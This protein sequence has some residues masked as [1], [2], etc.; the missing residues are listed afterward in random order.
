MARIANSLATRLIVF[1]LLLVIAGAAARFFLLPKFLSAGLIRVVSAQQTVLA[2]RVARDIDYKIVERRRFLQRVADTLPRELLTRPVPLRDWLQQRQRLQPLLS[3]SLAVTDAAG[4]LVADYPSVPG[5]GGSSLADDPVF[6]AA[7]AG[8]SAIGSPAPES[9]SRQTILPMAVPVEDG[10]GNV[11]A[12]LIGS[13]ALDAP[14][15]LGR[16]SPA[17]IGAAG[18][19][20]LFSSRDELLVATR[21]PSLTLHAPA[22]GGDRLVAGGSGV[23]VSAQGVANISAMASVPSAGW[24][25]VARMPTAE[26]L[27]M[28]EQEQAMILRYGFV[29]IL[30]ILFGASTMIVWLL[31]PLHRA[32]DRAEKMTRGEIALEPLP[33]VRADEVGHLTMAFNRLLDKLVSNQAELQHMAHHDALTGLPIAACWKIACKRRWLGRGD[34][35][36]GSRCC[37]WISTASSRSTI[38]WATRPETRS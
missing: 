3:M 8:K 6:R 24:F 4:R 21:D 28:V 34:A 32:A 15:F 38:R 10:A 22:K 30:I 36:P 35:V 20:R 14:E 31:S 11:R 16:L 13:A 37:F 1:G 27:G 7:R 17:R 9:S 26:A 25:V 33:V 12:V 2:D 5:R 18:G 23:T 19:F 29:A